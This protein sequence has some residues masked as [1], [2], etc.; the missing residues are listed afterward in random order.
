MT[1]PTAADIRHDWSRA[2]VLALFERPF[3][4]LLHTAHTLHRRYF[5]PHEV[6]ASTLLSI[7]TGACPEDCK[8]CPQSVR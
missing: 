8:Y 5:D 3:M 7:K 1:Q 2:E 4:D 6:Q